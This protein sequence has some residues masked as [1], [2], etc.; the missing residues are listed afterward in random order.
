MDSFN[1]ANNAFEFQYGHRVDVNTH[2]FIV[3]RNFLNLSFSYMTFVIKSNFDEAGF[4]L[5]DYHFDLEGYDYVINRNNIFT[6][7][8]MIQHD[9]NK[10]RFILQNYEKLD[11][12]LL[13]TL[14]Y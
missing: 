3:F 11:V 5:D 14:N 7:G 8:T 9:F 4:H 13:E 10:T 1:Q 6:Q 2:N 12:N